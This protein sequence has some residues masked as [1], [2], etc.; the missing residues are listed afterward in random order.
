M[1]ARPCL[2]LVWMAKD[3]SFTGHLHSTSLNFSGREY[4]QEQGWGWFGDGLGHW[5]FNGLG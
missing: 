1:A 2:N 4:M 5:A 3:S